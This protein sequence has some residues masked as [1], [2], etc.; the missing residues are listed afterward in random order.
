V[1]D[2][3][4][5]Q[6]VA[7]AFHKAPGV[8]PWDF[9][10]SPELYVTYGKALGRMHALTTAY[11]PTDAQGFRPAWDHP[12]ILD[13]EANLTRHDPI[14]LEK[15]QALEERCRRLP[16]TRDV[17]GLIHFDA[18]AANFLVDTVDRITFFD[19]DDCNYNWLAYDLAIVIFY[20]VMWEQDKPAFTRYFLDHFLSGYRQE[21]RLDPSWLETIPMFLKMREIDLYGVVYRDFDPQEL[22]NPWI[23]GFMD[24]RKERIHADLPYV[25]MDFSELAGWL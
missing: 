12:T 11:T 24:G 2:G 20:M 19:F 14:A 15:F 21:F 3:H 13:V 7:T 8:P 23:R 6:F 9:G 25:E 22:A 4:G 17:F 10:W 16:Q 18:H 5:A 1:D